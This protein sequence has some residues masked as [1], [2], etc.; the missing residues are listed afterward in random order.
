MKRLVSLFLLLVFLSGANIS[1][2]DAKSGNRKG[3]QQRMEQF[4]AEKKKFLIQRIGLSENE[5]RQFFPIYEEMQEKKMKLNHSVRKMA[6]EVDRS[7][8]TLSDRAYLDAADAL[9]SLA[10]KEAEIDKSYYDAIKKILSPQKLLKFQRAEMAF[11]KE[12]LRK[13]D[14]K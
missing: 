6:R 8:E 13:H 1:A 9:Q 4:K 11:A 10:A 2:Q 7:A 12:V 5:S 3:Q 14:K